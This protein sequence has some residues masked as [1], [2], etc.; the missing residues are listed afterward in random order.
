MSKSIESI[1]TKDAKNTF[2]SGVDSASGSAHKAIDSASD[3]AGPAIKKATSTA[4]DTVDS[5][6]KGAH[7]A[8]DAISEKNAQLHNLQQQLTDSTRS[9]V[10]NNPLLSLGVAVAGGALF[11][12]WLNSRSGGHDAS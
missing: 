4:H 1:T 3:A 12:M 2:D 9:H 8:A 6:A 11:A 10:R 7:N 5:M